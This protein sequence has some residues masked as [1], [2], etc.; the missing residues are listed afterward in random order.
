MKQRVYLSGPISGMSYENARFGWRE[1]VAKQLEKAGIDSLSP[2]RAKQHL[3]NL[4]MQDNLSAWGDPGSVLSCSR[5]IMTRDRFDTTRADLVFM[6]LLGADRVS[7]G[8]M[9]ELAWADLA[10]PRRIPVV[11]VMELA[12]NL[13]DHCM[14]QE[15][16]GFRC[17]TLDEA[18]KVTISVLLPGV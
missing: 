2:M 3:V 10:Q 16:I 5:G 4:A 11:C 17:E 14:V 13:H 9:M 18:I 1:Y 15:A 8:T 12:G 6:N 7:I